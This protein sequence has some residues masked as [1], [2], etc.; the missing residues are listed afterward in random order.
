MDRKIETVRTYD[1]AVPV[2]SLTKRTR[3]GNV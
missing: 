1:N 3:H 2:T